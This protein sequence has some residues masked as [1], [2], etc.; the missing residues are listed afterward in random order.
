MAATH[1]NPVLCPC[2]AAAPARTTD[3]SG[4]GPRPQQSGGGTCR[5]FAGQL[6]AAC[7]CERQLLRFYGRH[8][9]Q[10]PLLMHDAIAARGADC[11]VPPP[12]QVRPPGRVRFSVPGA[13]ARAPAQRRRQKPR[14]ITRRGALFRADN[15]TRALARALAVRTWKAETLHASS[16]VRS[17]HW[18]SDASSFYLC[19]TSLSFLHAR[20]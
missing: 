18:Q 15:A 5:Y 6:Y 16:L 4:R 3:C 10:W 19:L 14:R 7:R 13:A 1:L 9:P 8:M 12:T 17:P 2:P 11:A 20:V